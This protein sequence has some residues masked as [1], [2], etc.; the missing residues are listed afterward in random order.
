MVDSANH[1]IC[2]ADLVRRGIVQRHDLGVATV[3][4]NPV[5]TPH[6]PPTHPGDGARGVVG[7]L[8]SLTLEKASSMSEATLALDGRSDCT[9]KCPLKLAI[10]LVVTELSHVTILT[11]PTTVNW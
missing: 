4:E 6:V 9:L 2:P 5:Y 3:L 1:N 8:E 7:R 11:S 10:D